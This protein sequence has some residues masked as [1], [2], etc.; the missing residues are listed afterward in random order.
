M[1]P[2]QWPKQ[3]LFSP[4]IRAQWRKRGSK[5]T[6][7]CCAN[8]RTWRKMFWALRRR[9][10]PH[11]VLSFFYFIDDQSSINPQ[12]PKELSPM[13]TDHLAEHPVFLQTVSVAIAQLK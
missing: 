12:K 5:M 3:R 1:R 13:K 4:V 7:S 2:I 8:S 6:L 9:P 10:S 11:D